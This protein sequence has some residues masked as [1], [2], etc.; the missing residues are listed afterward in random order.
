MENIYS[1]YLFVNTLEEFKTAAFGFLISNI[2]KFRY[3]DIEEIKNLIESVEYLPNSKH[4][5]QFRDC[6]FTLETL[7]KDY[8]CS[9]G[10]NAV[11]SKVFV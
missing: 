5:F 2:K 9:N 8:Y 7:T 6:N 3:S 4:V 1:C 11:I 10:S